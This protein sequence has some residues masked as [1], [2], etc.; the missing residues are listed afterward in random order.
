MRRLTLNRES[1]TDLT[2]DEL[3]DVAGGATPLC[4][5]QVVTNQASL[6]HLCN[7]LSNVIC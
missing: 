3:S 2:N 1:L 5:T 6:C 7:L 4:P